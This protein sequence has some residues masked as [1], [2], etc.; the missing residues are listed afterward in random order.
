MEND[1]APVNEA[2]KQI[3]VT[4]GTVNIR[5][6]P[7]TKGK[8]IKVS[9]KGQEYSAT[10]DEENGWFGIYLDN[11]KGWISGKYAEVKK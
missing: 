11:K 5:D 8:I 10:G 2:T 6:L 7:S 4:G 9:K 3:V 1:D